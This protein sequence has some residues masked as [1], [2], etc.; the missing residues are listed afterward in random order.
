M[1]RFLF[2]LLILCLT[3]IF[4][5]KKKGERYS[6]EDCGLVVVVEN[7]CECGDECQIMCCE[8]PMKQD[9][10]AEKSSSKSTMKT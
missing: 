3:V 2:L 10:N 8:K 4:L 9:K 5:V 7:A 6:C 1:E